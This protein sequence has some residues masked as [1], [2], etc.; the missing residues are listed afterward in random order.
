[1]D[2]LYDCELNLSTNF[3]SISYE[4]VASHDEWKEAMHKEYDAFIKNGT[5]KLVGTPFET[6]PI[7]CKWVFNN[8]YK[9]DDSFDKHKV[10]LVEK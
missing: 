5:W 9:Y 2:I 10:R 8:K 1:M 7:G 4:Q 6:K 3:E